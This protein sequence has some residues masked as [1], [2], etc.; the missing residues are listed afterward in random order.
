[1]SSS[2]GRPGWA[3]SPLAPHIS[4]RQE[5]QYPTSNPS[6]PVGSSQAPSATWK[7]FPT[8][9]GMLYTEPAVA[10]E[11]KREKRELP[12]PPLLPVKGRGS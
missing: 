3:L 6:A 8:E 11:R 5:Y 7:W 4:C 9:V 1:M 12:L 2:L 10:H